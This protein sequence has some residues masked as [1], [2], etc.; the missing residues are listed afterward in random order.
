MR[1]AAVF[2]EENSLPGP[3]GKATAMYGNDFTGAG[4]GHT[5]VTRAVVGSLTSVNQ[6]GQRL[7]NEMIKI[8]MKVSPG[9]GV[10]VFHDDETRAGVLH[11]DS[12][13]PRLNGTFCDKLLELPGDF[14]GALS[15]GC[16]R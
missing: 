4:Q 16:H 15:P 13:L 3:E 2:E 12:E 8:G 9:I 6:E 7:R 10:G 1:G 11:K 5:K 14:I